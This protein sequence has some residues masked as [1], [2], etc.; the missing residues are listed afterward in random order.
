[1][2]P[3]FIRTLLQHRFLIWQLSKREV[4]GRYRGSVLGIL[5][6]LV[7]P[8]FM[9]AVYTFVFSVVFKARW[10]DRGVEENQFQ[11]AIVL[12]SGLIVH[13]LFA[14]CFNRA[15]TLI[16]NNANYVKKVIFP[17]EILPY[18]VLI[19]AIFHALVSY[20]ILFVFYALVHHSLQWTILFLPLV[21]I[22]FLIFSMGVSWLL[23]SLGVFLRDIGQL[24]MVLTTVL[25]FVSPIFFP[26]ERVPE[27]LQ[28]FI[29]ANPL[30]FIVN[31][32]REVAL[33]G[34]LPDWKG[35]G[36]YLLVSLIVAQF[37]FWWFQRTRKG[38]AD[39]I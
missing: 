15:P 1:M 9:L 23:A 31:Q 38:F 2:A 22:P 5:W 27:F 32:S 19:S 3:A 16:L 35:L 14:E 30:T 11:F 17:L 4:I 6:S 28:P 29:Y 20:F 39:V 25:L 24:T 26:V 21:L 12:F 33:F 8:L 37:G 18:T 7:N 36:I 34:N 13:S 10:A